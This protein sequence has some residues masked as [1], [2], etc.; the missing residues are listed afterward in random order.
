MPIA[1]SLQRSDTL[2]TR[3]ALSGL[4]RSLEATDDPERPNRDWVLPISSSR[5]ALVL[6]PPLENEDDRE[7][8]GVAATLIGSRK[9]RLMDSAIALPAVE[10]GTMTL[11]ARIEP[12]ARCW[13]ALCF[14]PSISSC[15]R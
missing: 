14:K 1:L 11:E 5:S 8:E 2:L 6:A 7:R 13:F 9:W 10:A 15:C 3:L 12:A 4:E